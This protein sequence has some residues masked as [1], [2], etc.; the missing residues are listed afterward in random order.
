MAHFLRKKKCF[1]VVGDIT[2]T[3]NKGRWAGPMSGLFL[4]MFMCKS[5]T[6]KTHLH[7]TGSKTDPMS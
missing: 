1:L 7:A 5:V 6:K 3:V 4:Y 2:V